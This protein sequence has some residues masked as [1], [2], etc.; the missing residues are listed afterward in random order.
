MIKKGRGKGKNDN[1]IENQTRESKSGSKEEKSKMKTKD[2]CWV[3]SEKM[4]VLIDAFKVRRLFSLIFLLH[5][6]SE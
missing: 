4:T 2:K 6:M 5:D 1:W 3:K